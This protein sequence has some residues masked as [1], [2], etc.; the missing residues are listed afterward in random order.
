M[1]TVL[2]FGA[3]DP[4]HAGHAHLLADA[5][6]YGDTL[7]VAL[8]S[9]DAIR[10][11]K[12]HEPRQ[13]FDERKAALMLLPSVDDVL[14][15]MPNDGFAVIDNVLPDV[16]ATGYDQHHLREALADWMTTHRTIPVVS[17]DA[18]EPERYK[19]SLLNQA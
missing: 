3:F 1:T 4:L 6:A 14:P 9:D 18:H 8:A 5:A 17:V 12:H 16:I 10:Q 19:S 11:L 13:T 15:S 7:V 2:A